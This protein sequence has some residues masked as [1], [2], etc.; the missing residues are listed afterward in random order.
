MVS[1]RRKPAVAVSGFGDH[2]GKIENE[3]RS[4]HGIVTN[5]S[6]SCCMGMV[7]TL[8]RKG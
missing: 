3:V 4:L 2:G 1:T 6:R 5:E 8:R 7:A